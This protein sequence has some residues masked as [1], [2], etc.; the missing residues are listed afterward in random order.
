MF[1]QL[2]KATYYKGLQT[3]FTQLVKAPSS[4]MTKIG[5]VILGLCFALPKAGCTVS[6]G[7]RVSDLAVAQNTGNMLTT[8][9]NMTKTTGQINRRMESMNEAIGS[10]MGPLGNRMELIN[11]GLMIAGKCGDPF[12]SL[13]SFFLGL[14]KGIAFDFD[15]CNLVGAQKSYSNLLFVPFDQWG[16][17]IDPTRQQ[18]LERNRLQMIQQSSA[19]A[20]AVAAFE[21]NE[22]EEKRKQIRG[23]FQKAME[24][25]SFRE[26]MRYA[27]QLLTIIAQELVS[28][29]LIQVHQTEVQATLAAE[30][31]PLR[32]MQGL[33]K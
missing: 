31:V 24:T 20:L 2:V 25:K 10:V 4:K 29:R 5:F 9:G 6:L 12:A 26:D 32:R 16:N 3:M 11:L 27:N 13:K 19:N 18:E 33:M 21:R 14:G 8:L 1:T 23:V 15:F 22:I 28:L 7:T 30:Q 17:G